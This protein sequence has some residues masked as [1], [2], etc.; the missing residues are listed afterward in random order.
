M[1]FNDHVVD[2]QI[3]KFVSTSVP[4]AVE[5]RLRSQLADFRSRL[6]TQEPALA[7]HAHGW[8]RLAA[9]WRLGATCAAVVALLAM[10]GL[11]LRPQAGLA[12]VKAAVVRADRIHLRDRCLRIQLV[13]SK[14]G[15]H[16]PR[17]SRRSDRAVL[18]GLRI[19][20]SMSFT[21]STLPEQNALSRQVGGDVWKRPK[22]LDP[23]STRSRFS[24][25]QTGPPISRWNIWG[26][27][28][29]IATR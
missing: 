16:P 6:S 3:R 11:V 12:D 19:T 23:C 8:V 14:V 21:L 9:W 1:D 13:R 17:R 26:S 2:N 15:F 7:R 24:C 10:A 27:S 18:R 22:L 20:D 28:V 4:V 5:S 25:K 29:P